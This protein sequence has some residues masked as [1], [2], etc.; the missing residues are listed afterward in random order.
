[1]PSKNRCSAS[2]SVAAKTR[3][4]RNLERVLDADLYCEDEPRPSRETLHLTL[5]LPA[6]TAPALV[7]TPPQSQHLPLVFSV[8]SVLIPKPWL[9]PCSAPISAP[10]APT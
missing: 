4:L 8:L 10:W 2:N 1:M 7:D 3:N 5:P 9:Y 6:S